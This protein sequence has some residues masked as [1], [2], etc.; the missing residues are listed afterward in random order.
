MR[1]GEKKNKQRRVSPAKIIADFKNARNVAYQ[2][3]STDFIFRG[4]K[5]PL[6]VSEGTLSLTEQISYL[7]IEDVVFLYI[8]I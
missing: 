8:F 2:L 7:I 3:L 6:I 5:I 4:T 1:E